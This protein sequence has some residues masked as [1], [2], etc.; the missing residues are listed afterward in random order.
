MGFLG[1]MRT[2]CWPDKVRLFP[3]SRSIGARR[4]GNFGRSRRWLTDEPPSRF[5]FGS[6]REWALHLETR[7]KPRRS[8]RVLPGDRS[9]L[10]NSIFGGSLIALRRRL[11]ASRQ[12]ESRPEY[13]DDQV[14]RTLEPSQPRSTHFIIDDHRLLFGRGGAREEQRQR[15]PRRVVL[16]QRIGCVP[17]DETFHPEDED[18]WVGSRSSRARPMNLLLPPSLRP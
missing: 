11:R 9:L 10:L 15:L 18:P 16:I 5:S 3:G 2:L 13:A 1:K 17:P 6:R 8:D 7:L 4:S 14:Q 12:P